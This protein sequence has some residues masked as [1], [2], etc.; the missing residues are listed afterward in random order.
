LKV[1]QLGHAEEADEPDFGIST[2]AA[3]QGHRRTPRASWAAADGADGVCG[4]WSLAGEPI[5][6]A[7]T[8]C[9]C[10]NGCGDCARHTLTWANGYDASDAR[11]RPAPPAV[12]GTCFARADSTSSSLGSRLGSVPSWPAQVTSFSSASRSLCHS[13][14]PTTDAVAAWDLGRGFEASLPPLLGAPPQIRWLELN[15]LLGWACARWSTWGHWARC[16][17]RHALVDGHR[18]MGLMGAIEGHSI[19]RWVDAEGCS[20]YSFPSEALSRCKVESLCVVCNEC[21]Q[22]VSC[23]GRF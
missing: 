9:S 16:G 19:Q 15:R 3:P 14:A 4:S 12:R 18:D 10:L 11:G 23:N 13:R 17:G 2:A 7:W 5:H 8:C 22:Y 20:Y 1:V 21:M 6:A